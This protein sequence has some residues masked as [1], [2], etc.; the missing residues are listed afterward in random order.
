MAA[1]SGRQFV[2]AECSSVLV[3][4]LSPAFSILLAWI[5]LERGVSIFLRR[6]IIMPVTLE[7]HNPT[8]QHRPK[9]KHKQITERREI[10]VNSGFIFYCSSE[11]FFN[12]GKYG[13]RCV[14]CREIAWPV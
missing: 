9:G 1:A 13:R 4:P 6:V 11:P 12:L 3:T 14:A 10:S 7:S 8:E 2:E 5:S